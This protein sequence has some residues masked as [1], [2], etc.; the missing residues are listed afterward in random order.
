MKDMIKKRGGRR[1]N[2]GRRSVLG[3]TVR[4]DIRIPEHIERAAIRLG[5][6]A[7]ADGVRQM[8]EEYLRTCERD[9]QANPPQPNDIVLICTEGGRWAIARAVED[10]NGDVTFHEMGQAG[11][12]HQVETWRPLP[13]AEPI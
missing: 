13:S 6:G 1:E 11:A 12:V 3:P 9:V 7:F 8:C 2:A 10:A 4:R 5:K